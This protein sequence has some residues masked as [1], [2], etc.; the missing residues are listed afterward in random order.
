MGSLDIDSLLSNMEKTLSGMRKQATEVPLKK[1]ETPKDP[2][3]GVGEEKID[4]TSDVESTGPDG[5]EDNTT[6]EN[7]VEKTYKETDGDKTVSAEKMANDILAS[8]SQKSTMKKAFDKNLKEKGGSFLK[9]VAS[10]IDPKYAEVYN[11]YR[12]QGV[13]QAVVENAMQKQAAY[14]YILGQQAAQEMMMKVAAD[15]APIQPTIDQ[16][17]AQQ[18]I[19]QAQKEQL[20]QQLGA[21]DVL[22]EASIMAATNGWSSQAAVAKA[23][24]DQINGVQ[25]MQVPEA[26]V[27]LQAAQFPAKEAALRMLY[28][29]GL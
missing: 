5:G 29:L 22:D 17:L 13:A 16:L 23:L 2:E 25:G 27:A 8:L 7:P 15:I 24:L 18:L 12:G 26:E 28:G 20:M 3:E 10:M 19:D 6:G 9:K 4:N 11:Y 14:D 21:A 1:I